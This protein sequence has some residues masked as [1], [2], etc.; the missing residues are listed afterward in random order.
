MIDFTFENG[1][2]KKG[3]PLSEDGYDDINWDDCVSKLG[4]ELINYTRFGDEF[5]SNAII[6]KH[7]TND[8]SLAEVA[9]FYEE[10]KVVYIPD[11][12]SLM[13]FVRDFCSSFS[14]SYLQRAQ[15]ELNSSVN[16]IFRAYHG[17]D[18]N[19]ICRECDPVEFNRRIQENKEYLEYRKK[20]ERKKTS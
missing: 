17:H 3:S 15:E 4:Y 16:K 7:K 13:I 11:F 2:W 8:S 1:I 5:S 9:I 10:Y 6:R 20:K 19:E 18:S 12:P 14:L